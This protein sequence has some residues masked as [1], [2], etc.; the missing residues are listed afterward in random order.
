MLDLKEVEERKD[1]SFVQPPPHNLVNSVS[2]SATTVDIEMTKASLLSICRAEQKL[3]KVTTRIVLAFLCLYFGSYLLAVWRY[4]FELPLWGLCIASS[5]IWAS[6]WQQSEKHKQAMIALV[7][8]EVVTS[9]GAL[10]EILKM[11]DRE[12]AFLVRQALTKILPKL[13]ASEASLLNSYQ[14]T[15]L[16]TALNRHKY[17]KSDEYTDF[18]VAVLKSYEQIGGEDDIDTVT[19]IAASTMIYDL[20]VKAAAIECLPYLNQRIVEVKEKDELLRASSFAEIPNRELLRPAQGVGDTPAIDLLR[21]S[22]SPE[23]QKGQ[24]N[25]KNE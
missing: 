25:V 3:R 18:Q 14:R 16:R 8:D 22:K 20:R 4:N 5:I 7:D 24:T 1:G 21:P 10:S 19:Q 11:H 17:G 2:K 15:V 9:V 12:I 23:L 6:F 13:R